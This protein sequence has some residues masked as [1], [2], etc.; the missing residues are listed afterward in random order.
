MVSPRFGERFDLNWLCNSFA[1]RVSTSYLHPIE[2]GGPL[3]LHGVGRAEN[4][5]RTP[6]S[7]HD[8]SRLGPGL[9]RV[10]MNRWSTILTGHQVRSRT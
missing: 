9:C 7:R 3:P 10:L 6:P 1:A 5:G 2:T 4:S 8:L